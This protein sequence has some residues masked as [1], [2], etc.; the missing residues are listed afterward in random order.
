MSDSEA[1]KGPYK[2][3][4]PIRFAGETE[5][6]YIGD[7]INMNIANSAWLAGRASRDEAIK[8][9]DD[10][11]YIFTNIWALDRE[12]FTKEFLPRIKKALEDDGG[13]K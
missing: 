12:K 11:N 5:D 4:S 8:I 13:N 7:K 2:L 6:R 10:V 9:L 1:A 3:C